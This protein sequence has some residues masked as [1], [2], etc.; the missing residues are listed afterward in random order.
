MDDIVLRGIA[1]WPDVPAVYGWLQLDRRGRWLIRGERI[2]NPAVNDFI[3]RNYEHDA[4]GRW[5]FQNGPQ[6]V[7]A[8]LDY[9]P[10]VYRI[11]GADGVSLTLEAHTGAA[12]TALSGAWIDD[13]GATLID[14]EHGVG[15]IHD[16]DLERLLPCFW[17]TT[18]E[19]LIDD[20]LAR[21]MDLIAQGNHVDIALRF[22]GATLKVAPIAARDVPQRFGFVPHPAPP[23]GHEACA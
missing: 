18:G 5:F 22:G 20:V 2:T 8:A 14:T 16:Q 12:A 13:D 10:F 3:G 6:R 9:T 4:G 15:L 19:Q 11:V 1:K 21:Q 17:A 7:F 23:A